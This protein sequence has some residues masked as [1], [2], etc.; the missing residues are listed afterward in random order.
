VTLGG[1]TVYDAG[2]RSEPIGDPVEAALSVRDDKA[3]ALKFVAVSNIGEARHYDAALRD[4]V[5]VKVQVPAL[6]SM[7]YRVTGLKFYKHAAEIQYHDG[8]GRLFTLY[9]R[10][11][12]ATPASISSSRTACMSASGRTT[13]SAP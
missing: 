10:P 4:I 12:T 5:G 6:G 3:A 9:L 13:G 8:T 7:G 1:L 2:Y 11:R